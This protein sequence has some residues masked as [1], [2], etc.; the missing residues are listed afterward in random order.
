MPHQASTEETTGA[1]ATA[2]LSHSPAQPAGVSTLVGVIFVL[3]AITSWGA[4]FPYTKIVLAKLSSPVFLVLRFGIGAITLTLLSFATRRTQRPARKDWGIILGAALVGIV[5]HQWTQLTGLRFT[6]ATNT[7]WI[8]TLIPPVTGL[9][10]WSFLR[11]RVTKRQLTGLAIALIGVTLFIARGQWQSLSMIGNR[12]DLLVFLSV[13]TWSGYTVMTR[14]RLSHYDP[15]PLTALHMTL[16]F[17]AFLAVGAGNLPEQIGRL[18]MREWVIVAAIGL[19]PSGLAYYWW[20]AGLARL[21]SLNTSMFIFIEAVVASA[22]GWVL[23]G[24]Q[25]TRSMAIWAIVIFVGVA[26]AQTQ[27][28]GL[29]PSARNDR[30]A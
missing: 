15:L 2:A 7:G 1:A 9:M 20:N 29:S 3:A 28:T 16:G 6:S 27:R 24:E 23:L 14:A 17:V 19:V 21:G 4:N 5:L 18:T 22:A 10:A 13:F 8:L 26:I 30:A 25:F 11:E 12:G